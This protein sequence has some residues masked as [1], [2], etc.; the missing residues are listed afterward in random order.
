M[1]NK[2]RSYLETRK[3]DVF[4]NKEA[5]QTKLFC[6][7]YWK[8]MFVDLHLKIQAQQDLI[9]SGAVCL[10]FGHPPGSPFFQL[11]PNKCPGSVRIWQVHKN[12]CW[13]S[14]PCQHYFNAISKSQEYKLSCSHWCHMSPLE[15]L[16]FFNA[17]VLFFHKIY[18]A[19]RSSQTIC[20]HLLWANGSKLVSKLLHQLLKL[21]FKRSPKLHSW[22]P[23]GSWNM[24]QPMLLYYLWTML[25]KHLENAQLMTPYKYF[26]RLVQ[27][28]FSF[29]SLSNAF[30]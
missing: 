4:L 6:I 27:W 12:V 19:P 5:S 8:T 11:G 7:Q 1:Q 13:C 14:S 17:S 23:R 10:H 24:A 29:P 9:K 28:H 16:G 25:C 26:K 30:T 21:E 18:H 15:M 22:F 20:F 2:T 3:M